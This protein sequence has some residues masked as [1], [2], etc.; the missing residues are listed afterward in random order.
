MA[1]AAGAVAQLPSSMRLGAGSAREL[2]MRRGHHKIWVLVLARAA[3]RPLAQAVAQAAADAADKLVRA[4]HRV[5]RSQ[6]LQ[7]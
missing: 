4:L 6:C 5:T 3:L 1:R 7:A 2:Q